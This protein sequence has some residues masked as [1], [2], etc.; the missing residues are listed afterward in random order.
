[1]FDRFAVR[2]II[3]PIV[4]PFEP[5]RTTVH[6]QGLQQL[7][8][9]LI[10]QGVHGIFVAGTTGE[11]WALGDDQWDRLVRISAEVCQNRVPLYA[12]V[13][14]ASTA[15]ACAR[16]RRASALGADF[17]VS[18]APYYMAPT[19]DDVVRHFAALAADSS[20]PVLIYQFPGISK[21]SIRVDTF[22]RLAAIPGIIGVKDTQADIAVFRE[23]RDA[24]RSENRDF[25]MLLGSDILTD[26]AVMLGADGSIPALANLAAVDLVEV[27]SA[28]CAGDYARAAEAQLRADRY[29]KIFFVLPE[30]GVGGAVTGIKCALTL[31]GV[32]AGLPAEPLPILNARQVAQVESLLDAA[33]ARTRH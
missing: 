16:A 21:V 29:R 3:P 19:Q 2:G 14:H 22:V 23:M 26:V 11:A 6:E 32:E 4:T 28:A 9:R 30:G 20:L 25:R 7:I 18:L 33:G 5:D 24:L 27:Y 17:V 10:N 1:V 13:S 31:L 8:E 15:G 12:G